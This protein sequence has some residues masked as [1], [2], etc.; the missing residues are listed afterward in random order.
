MVSWLFLSTLLVL[1]P[2]LP[3]IG[4]AATDD[5]ADD[6]EPNADVGYRYLLMEVSTVVNSKGLKTTRIHNRIEIQKAH[7]VEAIGDISIRYNGFRSEARVNK[8]FTNNSADG[9]NGAA[10][11]G[12]GARPDAR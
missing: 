7:A 3:V 4:Q 8:A 1:A 5:G 10:E 6:Q 2:C 12:G 9:L 11:K